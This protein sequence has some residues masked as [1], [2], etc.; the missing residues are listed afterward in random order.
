MFVCRFCVCLC[1]CEC[2]EHCRQYEFPAAVPSC[3]SAQ[4][5]TSKLLN[6]YAVVDLR[7]S[8]QGRHILLAAKAYTLALSFLIYITKY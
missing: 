2:A 8:R 7:P 3:S 5:P 6:P 1:V 4:A